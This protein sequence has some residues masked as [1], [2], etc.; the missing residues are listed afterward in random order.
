MKNL[1]ANLCF[2][3]SFLNEEKKPEITD[4]FTRV[5]TGFFVSQRKKNFCK[6]NQFLLLF[7]L[8]TVNSFAQ[9]N[10]YYIS[11]SGDDSNNGLSA[12]SAWKTVSKVSAFNFEPGDKALFEGGQ[13]FAGNLEIQSEDG[14]LAIGSFGNGK[15]TINAGTGT[16]IYAFNAGAILI[17]N[18]IIEGNGAENN[19][20]NGIYFK[21]NQANDVSNIIIDSTEIYGFGGAGIILGALQTN[22]G[23]KNVKIINNDVHDNGKVGITSY[24]NGDMYNHGN[25]YVAYNK[26]YNNKGRI[27]IT[28]TNT[29]NGIVLSGVDGFIVEHCEA[30]GNGANNR[31]AGGGPVGIWCYNAKN[32]IIQFCESHHN[33]AGLQAD[34]GG[35]DIDGGSQNCVV[36]YNFSHDNEGPGYALFEYGS[37]N[38]FT[39]DTIRYNISENDGLKNG[40][41]ALGLWAHDAANKITNAVVYNN[42]FYAGNGAAGAAIRIL[43]TNISNVNVFNNIFYCDGV[44]MLKGDP[45]TVT[46]QHNNY[47]STG[48]ANFTDGGTT[49]DP[50]LINPGTGK[51]GYQLSSSSP[52]IDAGLSHGTL[53]DFYGN[54][55]P[56]GI[57][58]DIGVCEF[59][60]NI[61]A[62]VIANEDDGNIA[63]NTI[64][65]DLTTRWSARGNNQWIKYRLEA[66][67]FIKT[68]KIAWYRGNERKSFFDIQTSADDAEWTTVYSGNSSGQTTAM[69]SYAVTP[70]SASYVRIVGHTNTLNDWNSITEVKILKDSYSTAPAEKALKIKLL[71]SQ[72]KSKTVLAWVPGTANSKDLECNIWPNPAAL[73][74]NLK[75][76]SFWSGADLNITDLTGKIVLKRK[77]VAASVQLNL[78]NQPKGIYV[79][80][81]SKNE[82]VITRKIMLQ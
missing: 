19:S 52:M 77:S 60:D 37:S 80:K 69:Q 41:G 59:A 44:P 18:L 35:F 30:Y 74:F 21:M 81:L 63:A 5:N 45:A 11:S 50:Q 7:V 55:V 57:T 6:K 14:P 4:P 16:A 10:T 3:C 34:G 32:G 72:N 62:S 29:G 12:A 56:H 79:L 71:T 26:T 70:A 54:A 33:K 78:A 58:A 42:V 20:G 47:F 17:H 24:G 43:N 67:I 68:V 38:Q 39:N 15:A 25:F 48:T 65:N 9:N 22:S 76:S 46:W 31:N 82:K 53:K 64:D 51:N 1:F 49:V 75:T 8:F 2:N 61:V 28:Y 13:R 36:Q 40:A 27:D 66:A 23:Y 73:I